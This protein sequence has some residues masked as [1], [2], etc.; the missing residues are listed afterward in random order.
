[1][2]PNVVMPIDQA[3]SDVKM[4]CHGTTRPCNNRKIF[5][6]E[7]GKENKVKTKKKLTYTSKYKTEGKLNETMHRT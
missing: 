2:R 4:E 1:M 7:R 3:G 6:D 5:R